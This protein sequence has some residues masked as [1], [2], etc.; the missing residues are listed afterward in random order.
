M[1][2]KIFIDSNIW[3]YLYS[4]K[5]IK[6]KVAEDII[7]K[8]FDS[9]IISFQV[10]H[11]VYNVLVMKIL[12]NKLKAREIVSKM[13]ESFYMIDSNF[14]LT[15]KAID[16]NIRYNYSFWDSLIIASAIT[17][18]CSIL[19]TEDMQHNQLIEG[20][21]RIVNPFVYERG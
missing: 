11:E 4:K 15:D 14:Y 3:I 6:A 7:D 19:Y 1:K 21:L 13:A 18:G 20:T 17:S 12:K 2:G 16:I 9:I 8:N 5:D 10:I